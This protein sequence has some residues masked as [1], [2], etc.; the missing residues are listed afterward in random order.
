MPPVP[1]L[2]VGLHAQAEMRLLW[3]VFTVLHGDCKRRTAASRQPPAA[4]RQP[5]CKA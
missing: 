4:S 2:H 1:L 5:H 3:L